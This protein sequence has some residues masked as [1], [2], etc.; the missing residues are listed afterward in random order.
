MGL[1][2]QRLPP[3]QILR[4]TEAL[5]KRRL[6]DD[7]GPSE[8]A[9]CRLLIAAR[10]T[11]AA[12]HILSQ[13]DSIPLPPPVSGGFVVN[14][15]SVYIQLYAKI[16]CSMNQYLVCLCHQ[17]KCEVQECA[18]ISGLVRHSSLFLYCCD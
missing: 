11:Q 12:C 3:V 4:A 8:E 9:A 5:V 15:L 16:N 18:T 2:G 6:K 7:M 17:K 14:K 1:V 10:T 13:K